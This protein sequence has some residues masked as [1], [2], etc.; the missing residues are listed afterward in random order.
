MSQR[1]RHRHHRHHPLG[2]LG[3]RCVR[4]TRAPWNIGEHRS[5]GMLPDMVNIE[6]VTLWLCQQFAIENDHRNSGFSH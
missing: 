2:D 1:H 3:M 4:R 6:K 5:D